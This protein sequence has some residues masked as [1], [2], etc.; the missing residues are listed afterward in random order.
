MLPTF[1]RCPARRCGGRGSR[2]PRCIAARTGSPEAGTAPPCGRG[3]A[4]AGS[5]HI[6]GRSRRCDAEERRL[7][8][9]HDSIL[10]DVA[11][12]TPRSPSWRF[13]LAVRSL[14][15]S[16]PRVG[17]RYGRSTATHASYPNPLRCSESRLSSARDPGRDRPARARSTYVARASAA[18]AA[19]S[20]FRLLARSAQSTPA[21]ASRCSPATT[22]RALVGGARRPGVASAQR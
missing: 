22:R 16:G 5:C 19:Y 7:H 9:D 1:S 21:S 12:T 11:D 8:P 3:G 15:R 4:T 17:A 2:R 20:R 14:L 13:P 18:I 6:A 10:P